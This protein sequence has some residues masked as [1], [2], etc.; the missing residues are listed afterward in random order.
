MITKK[1][2]DRVKKR[3]LKRFPEFKGIKPKITEK[4]IKPQDIL[5]KKLSMG[6]PKQV[7]KVFSMKFK[8]RIRTADKTEIERILT[9]TLDE[10]G[11]IIKIT[12]S[13]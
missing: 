6:A 3:V 8:K 2:I 10:A 1:T 4:R 12:Q 7:K 11:E 9:I 5:Y 13:R